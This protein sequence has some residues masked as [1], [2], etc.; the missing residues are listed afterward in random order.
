MLTQAIALLA[1][2]TC[3]S[4]QASARDLIQKMLTVYHGA[5]T[6]TGTIKLTVSTTSGSASLDTALQ[7]ERPSKFYLRQRKLVANPDPEQPTEWLV[8]SDGK[9][10]SYPVPNDKY[11]NAMGVRLV[12]PVANPRAG[13]IHD[14]ASIYAAASK[15]IG[16]RS[17]PLDIA[18]AARGDLVYRRAQWAT[19]AVVGEKQVRGKKANLIS[20]DFRQY[21]GAVVTGIYQMAVTDTGELLQYVEVTNVAVGDGPNSQ[22][23]RITSQWEVDL[24]INGKVDPTLFKVLVK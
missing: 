2:S 16:D 14:L 22:T 4:G 23:V 24:T 20:G 7:F 5:K 9:L 1:F 21:S 19:Y 12:E 17:M 11:A 18:I 15:S 13:S 6:M 8:S 3:H 10:F